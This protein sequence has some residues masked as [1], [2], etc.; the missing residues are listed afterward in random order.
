MQVLDGTPLWLIL[1]RIAAAALIV[2][3]LARP[4]LNPGAELSG[5]A[6]PGR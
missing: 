2:L 1:L 6:A 4:V 5:K 3:G